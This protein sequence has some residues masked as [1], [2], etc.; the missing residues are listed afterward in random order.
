FGSTE[1]EP[2]CHHQPDEDAA[3]VTAEGGGL[4]AGIPVP[5]ISLRVIRDRWGEKLGPME[6]DAFR[7]LEV[8]EGETGEIIVSGDHVLSGY[9]DGIGYGETKIHVDGTISH[10]TGYAGRID[11]HG[12]LW[13][14]GHCSEKLPTA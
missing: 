8:T 12:R 7:D 9:L 2:I 10:R 4:C 6:D 13:L 5:E 3:A 11:E 1:A 14:F